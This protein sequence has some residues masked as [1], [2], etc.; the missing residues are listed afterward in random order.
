M[1][2]AFFTIALASIL[3][4]SC[5]REYDINNLNDKIYIVGHGGMGVGRSPYP[6]NSYESI[7]MALNTGAD[8]AEIDVQISKDSVLVCFHDKYLEEATNGSGEIYTKNWD[9]IKEAIY[10]SPP[11]EEY[12]IASLDQIFRFSAGRGHFYTFDIKFNNPDT[13]DTN[14][15]IFQR[16]LIRLIEEYNLEERVS[17]ETTDTYFLLTMQEKKPDLY[18][19]LYSDFN[20][21]LEDAIEHGFKGITVKSDEISVENVSEAHDHGIM[22]AVFSASNRN[23]DDIIKTN[24]DIIQTD[25][26]RDLVS[27]LR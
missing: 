12:R 4:Y 24:V 8:G 3:L 18:F 15:D 6:L 25:D 17:I 22:V 26:L 20:S 2:K 9:E 10:K 19:F 16:A 27:K 13:S 11:F 5:E 14:R 23:H 21:A 7:E 1:Q